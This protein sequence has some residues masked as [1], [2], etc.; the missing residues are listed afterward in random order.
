M[1]ACHSMKEISSLLFHLH[2]PQED[3]FTS[4]I[5]ISCRRQSL[6]FI[7]SR[8]V[9]CA[10]VS[11]S[12]TPAC[13]IIFHHFIFTCRRQ[14]NMCSCVSETPSLMPVAAHLL[15]KSTLIIGQILFHQ[16]ILQQKAVLISLLHP[17]L[18]AVLLGFNFS[19]AGAC[20]RN[21]PNRAHTRIVTRAIR[22]I[23]S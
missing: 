16:A 12:F 7:F 14:T 10:C 6:S 13:T 4:L 2:L 9:R 21:S 18:W 8:P 11:E 1:P 3:A 15:G 23:T 22:V 20:A 17:A 5:F 19:Q